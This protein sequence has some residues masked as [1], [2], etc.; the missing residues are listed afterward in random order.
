MAIITTASVP[1][2]TVC[3]P[4]CPFRSVAVYPG[5][6]ALM[7]NAGRALAY[8]GYDSFFCLPAIAGAHEKGGVEGEI[9]RF[10]RRDVVAGSAP[11]LGGG[12][13]WRAWRGR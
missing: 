11:D 6:T 9:G 4:E 12:A 8:Y 13:R 10:R 3:V 7:R 2:L 5:S 1:S